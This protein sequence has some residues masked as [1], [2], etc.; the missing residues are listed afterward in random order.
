MQ[1][2][3]LYSGDMKKTKESPNAKMGARLKTAIAS[4]GRGGK[5]A[6][7]DLCGV[8]PQ[9]ITSWENTGCISKDKLVV[10]AKV[11]GYNINWIITGNGNMIEAM[12]DNAPARTEKDSVRKSLDAILSACD[13]AMRHSGREF[14]D[15]EK[16]DIYL[17]GIEFA[18][19]KQLTG[20]LVKQYLG[21]MI[22]KEKT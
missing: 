10:V 8:S 19:K 5:K 15:D 16:L 12:D 4:L 17:E 1:S 18:G 11:T 22:K 21:E 3:S 7:A 6:I 13:M 2:I 9:A 14:T 20:E